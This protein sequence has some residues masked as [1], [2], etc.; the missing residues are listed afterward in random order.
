MTLFCVL[1]I[2]GIFNGCFTV[3][4]IGW[5][6]WGFL[7]LNPALPCPNLGFIC[8]MSFT[9]ETKGFMTC[10]SGC[11]F[12]SKPLL[13]P[14]TFGSFIPLDFALRTVFALTVFF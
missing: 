1:G 3:W 11:I 12:R 2:P 7:H 14:W 4:T 10:F 13:T 8:G 9:F 6:I 5:L